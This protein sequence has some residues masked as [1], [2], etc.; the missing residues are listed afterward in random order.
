LESDTLNA[1]ILHLHWIAFMAD[2]PSFFRSI[3]ATQPIVWTLHDMNPFTGGCHFDSGCG[4]FATGCGSCPQIDNSGPDDVS[5]F[6]LMVKQKALAGRPIHVVAPSRWMLSQAQQSPVWPDT[7]SFTQINYGLDLKVFHPIHRGE[8]R[9]ALGLPMDATI[10]GFG[11]DQLNNPR[12]GVTYLQ[13]ALKQSGSAYK[14]L[15]ALVFGNGQIDRPAWTVN[16]IH[17]LGFV[18]DAHQ[19]ALAYSACDFF[20]IPSTEDNQPQMGIEAMA[21]GVPVLGFRSGGLAEMITDSVDG[22]LV[23]RL[24]ATALTQAIDWISE[25]EESRRLMSKRAR[26]TALR[27]FDCH[28]QTQRHLEIYRELSLLQN[29]T[30]HRRAA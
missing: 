19:Q 2:Y 8:A 24:N 23:E 26:A 22:I 20:V 16:Q 15:E 13:T 18:S 9:R 7:T 4:R 10:V 14:N 11:A 5:R 30:H 17:S 3:P 27:I 12:K 29:T 6:S 25:N 21:C 28:Q 1:D